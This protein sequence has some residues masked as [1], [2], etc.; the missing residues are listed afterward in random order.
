MI[1]PVLIGSEF[2][3]LDEYQDP[4]LDV[5]FVDISLSESRNYVSAQKIRNAFT[6]QAL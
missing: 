4:E 6:D 1:T 5:V 2:T 3:E